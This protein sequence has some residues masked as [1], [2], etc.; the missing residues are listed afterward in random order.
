MFTESKGNVTNCRLQL[1]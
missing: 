1:N